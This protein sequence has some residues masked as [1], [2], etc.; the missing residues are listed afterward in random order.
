MLTV[1]LIVDF[2][3]LQLLFVFQ[4]TVSSA[5]F[6]ILNNLKIKLFEFLTRLAQTP[7]TILQFV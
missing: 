6:K 3:E 5:V 1:G 2:E 7:S 4:V